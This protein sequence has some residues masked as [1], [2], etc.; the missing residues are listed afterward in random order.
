MVQTAGPPMAFA[1]VCCVRL[2]THK[3]W[4]HR[5]AAIKIAK[6]VI[7]IDISAHRYKNLCQSDALYAHILQELSR[8]KIMI[9]YLM[10][11]YNG[12][13]FPKKQR[14]TPCIGCLFPLG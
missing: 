3:R 4:A 8:R 9:I 1:F 6:P 12:V 10:Q 2:A 13:T 11:E 5:S 7:Y 14:G